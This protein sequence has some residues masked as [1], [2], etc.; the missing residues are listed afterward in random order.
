MENLTLF[1]DGVST[2]G[3]HQKGLA[4]LIKKELETRHLD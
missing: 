4:V 1:S 2:M 3:E